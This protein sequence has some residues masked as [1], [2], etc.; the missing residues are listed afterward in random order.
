VHT[1]VGRPSAAAMLGLIIHDA[2]ASVIPS[3]HRSPHGPR[4]AVVGGAGVAGAAVVGAPDP[5]GE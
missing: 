4:A 3:P 2:V 5:V 1:L